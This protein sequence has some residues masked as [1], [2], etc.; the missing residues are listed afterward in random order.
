MCIRD[1][2]EGDVTN[3]E[4]HYLQEASQY[5]YQ[6]RVGGSTVAQIDAGQMTL[7]KNIIAAAYK[8]NDAAVSINGSNAATDT[9]ATMPTCT[10]LKLGEWSGTFYFGHISR[11]T[12]YSRRVTNSQLKTLSST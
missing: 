9:S 6:I 2:I 3:N 12:Y 5:Q 7:S 4:R 8:L 10:K 11:F 1:R